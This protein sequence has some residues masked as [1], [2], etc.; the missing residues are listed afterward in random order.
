MSRVSSAK[1]IHEMLS[2]DVSEGGR[3][4]KTCDIIGRVMKRRAFSSFSVLE[5]I[6]TS[7]SGE[8][9]CA[10]LNV[11]A[12]LA[13]QAEDGEGAVGQLVCPQDVY[14]MVRSNVRIGD[15]VTLTGMFRASPSCVSELDSDAS[16]VTSIKSLKIGFKVGTAQILEKWDAQKLGEI[17]YAKSDVII[18]DVSEV[19]SLHGLEHVQLSPFHKAKHTLP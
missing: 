2:D 9:T 14:D 10:P 11:S 15:A 12:V 18:E 5:L 16:T 1:I 7:I 4:G 8:R 17:Y 13:L 3:R 19:E 6:V